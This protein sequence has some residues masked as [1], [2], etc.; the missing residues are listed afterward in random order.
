[1]PLPLIQT[2]SGKFSEKAPGEDV[3]AG[4]FDQAGCFR[5]ELAERGIGVGAGF[6]E[7]RIGFDHFRRH[8]LAADDEI[9]QGPLGL[10]APQSFGGNADLAQRVLFDAEIVH[11]ASA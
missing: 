3:V 7:Q 10:R 6:F 8:F 4:F 1:M 9:L 5:V 11:T 2:G